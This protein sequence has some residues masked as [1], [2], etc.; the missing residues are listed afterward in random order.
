MCRWRHP[1]PRDLWVAAHPAPSELRARSQR[2]PHPLRDITGYHPNYFLLG[3]R[4]TP[5]IPTSKGRLQRSSYGVFCSW[6][7]GTLRGAPW[8][9]AENLPLSLGYSHQGENQCTLYIFGS[10]GGWRQSCAS[11]CTKGLYTSI[12]HRLLPL[13]YPVR[14]QR[15]TCIFSV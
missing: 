8:K 10:L 9:E 15:L 5:S 4:A 13:S 3:F 1:T 14:V 6:G 2:N 11:R 7:P 12:L